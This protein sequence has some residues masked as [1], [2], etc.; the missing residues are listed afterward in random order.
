MMGG[1][2]SG[3]AARI[4]QNLMPCKLTIDSG[5][6]NSMADS[7]KVPVNYTHRE[8]G[9]EGERDDATSVLGV[10]GPRA[11][12]GATT[13]ESRVQSYYRRVPRR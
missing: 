7:L 8:R 2:W 6:K 10:R 9:R 3:L 12:V 1:G 4:C 5:G 11:C 13:A